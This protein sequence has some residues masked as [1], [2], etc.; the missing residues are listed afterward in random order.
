MGTPTSPPRVFCS[1]CGKPLPEGA[2]FC[3][4]CGAPSS[5]AVEGPVQP[6]PPAPAAPKPPATPVPAPAPKPAP[7]VYQVTLVNAGPNRGRVLV[8]L[9][10]ALQWDAPTA[11][12][13]VAAAPIVIAVG[14]P[15]ELAERLR[16]ALVAAGGMVEV[17]GPP[18]PPKIVAPRPPKP[19]PRRS[20][21][22]GIRQLR[23]VPGRRGARTLTGLA[24]GRGCTYLAYARAEGS[25]L[26]SSP[27]FI[28]VDARS[29]VPSAVR[30]GGSSS[31][32]AFG[33]RAL[34]GWVQDPGEV[35]LGFADELGQNGTAALEATRAFLKFLNYRLV[36]VL[37]PGAADPGE[38]AATALAVPAEWPAARIDLLAEAAAQSGF[39]VVRAIPDPLAAVASCLPPPGK[40][41]PKGEHFLV[42]DWGSQGLR[43]SVVENPP[44]G[45]PVVIDHVEQPLGGMWFD[46][47]LE[48]WL[49]ERLGADL[50]DEDRRAL[51]L[52]A[53][54]F[55]EEASSSFAEGRK[56]HVQ[57]CI[58]PAGLPPTRVSISKAELDSLFADAR[59]AVPGRRGGC[60][61]ARR[62]PPRA[63]RP[64]G[65]RGRRRAPVLRARRG[66]RGSG[67]AGGVSAEPRRIHRPRPGAVGN[68]LTRSRFMAIQV[69]GPQGRM[70]SLPEGALSQSL[71][72][73]L[74]RRYLPG[75]S[76]LGLVQVQPD[77]NLMANLR[78]LRI[79]EVAHGP[80][81]GR[82]LH[83]L[84]M[85]NVI[86]S[87]R[88]GSHSLVFVVSGE[89]S[90]VRV[91]LGLYKVDPTSHAHTADQIEVMASALRGN[92]PG[93]RLAGLGARDV[94]LELLRPIASLRKMGAITGIPSLKLDSE[95]HFVQGL[96][97]L[98]NSL[99]GEQYCLMV[100]A[101]PIPE[102]AVDEVIQRCRSLSS[103]IHAYVEG[104]YSDSIGQTT[105]H[106]DQK[107]GSL[108]GGIL[109]GGATLL[110]SMLGFGP[111]LGAAGPLLGAMVGGAGFSMGRTDT[112]SSSG[113]GAS[114]ARC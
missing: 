14:V 52:F 53:R 84:N 73:V 20:M 48:T 108:G 112:T 61:R 66:A 60:A 94:S 59:E 4:V 26:I 107:G 100:V 57:Y 45:P 38:S 11:G 88:D 56:D 34:N 37:G 17:K 23:E 80:D 81:V 16:Q 86:S 3:L 47:I 109:M 5:R 113:P 110:G 8:A 41:S 89:E 36:E 90:H 35:N 39:P 43:L 25:R 91:Y 49:A 83:A 21:S 79:L 85:Q 92:F 55:K 95:E 32:E 97:R 12:Q 78:F 15:A 2:R 87:F 1:S 111:L 82:S 103:E 62:F 77:A 9:R 31:A 33:T 93:I 104:T 10:Q 7:P 24:V 22:A 18:E 27:D 13:Y 64:G 40:G 19:E 69:T 99:R 71:L 50:P 67:E 28:R 72:T 54:H 30:L 46:M 76:D 58:V 102:T 74:E 106:A 105:S 98:T 63:F 65:N 75:M 29:M 42:I 44:D 96:E 51:S 114:A 101:E 70:M 68:A 6:A